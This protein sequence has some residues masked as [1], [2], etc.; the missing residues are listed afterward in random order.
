[1]KK[2][3]IALITASVMGALVYFLMGKE[4]ALVFFVIS[5]MVVLWT[6]EGIP[7][8]VVS[9]LPLIFFPAFGI[10]TIKETSLNF[11]E[12]VIFL[13]LGGFMMALAVEKTDLHK[14]LANRLINIFPATPT[15][16]VYGI[17]VTSGL[18]SAVL[19]NTTVTL[20]L[21]P[22]VLSISDNQ[23]IKIRLLLG[24]A[25]GASIG[26]VLTPVGTPP[27]LILIGFLQKNHLESITFV[28]WIYM[29][30]PVV[31]PMMVFVPFFLAFGVR[32]ETLENVSTTT[33]KADR[34]QKK[35]ML[36]LVSLFIL[37]IL[38]SKMDPWY[39]GLGLDERVILLTAGLIMFLPG[40][41]FL[42]WDDTRE[43][44]YE[45]I[46]LFGAGFAIADAFS[47]A[48]LVESFSAGLGN[49]AVLPPILIFLV[50]AAVV[51][52]ATNVT[53]NTAVVSI[54]LPVFFGLAMRLPF[55]SNAILLVVAVA[56]SFAFMLPI[57]TPPNAIVMSGGFVK[58]SQMI[59][60][61]FIVT[62]MGTFFLV[63]SA[64]LFWM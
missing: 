21:L 61:G 22:I 7:I 49:I 56:G 30:L 12:P 45:I 6:N 3:L 2:I 16:L 32:K 33:M 9:L 35:L 38:N 20:M 10:M 8:G 29:L 15:G 36:F 23:K 60:S 64:W 14:F 19:S 41:S 31:V 44:P 42:S 34:D 57:G 1:M 25:Y 51:T 43:I 55:E 52:A 54:A 63:L 48:H 17:V 59:R 4:K 58:T 13:F 50:A 5:L 40:F 11:A 28:K 26:G 27:N 18:L 24:L 46:F 47:R 39:N 62:L 37:L 53:S